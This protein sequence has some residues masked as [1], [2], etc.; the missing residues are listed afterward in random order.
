MY[1]SISDDPETQKKAYY[2]ICTSASVFSQHMDFLASAGYRGVSLSEGLKLLRDPS[3]ARPAKPVAIT[4]DDGFRN[5]ASEAWPLLE[6]HQFS[7]TIFLATG[8]LAHSPRRHRFNDTECLTWNEAKMLQASGIE[9]GAHTVTHPKLFEMSWPQIERELHDS[10]HQIE[11][12]LGIRVESFAYPYSFPVKSSF[13]VRLRDT[14]ESL[15]YV[16]CV[17]T[18]I[19]RAVSETDLFELPRLPV[20]SADDTCLLKSKLDGDYDW[21]SLPQLWAKKVKTAVDGLS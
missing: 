1:H 4:F 13:R 17:T 15:G 2:R 7:A 19:G 5:N 3:A 8:Y 16:S 9:L 12:E 11:D 18:S 21:L 20:N 14:L 10:K 6:K